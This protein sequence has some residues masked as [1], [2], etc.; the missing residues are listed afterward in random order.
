MTRDVFLKEIEDNSI[1]TVR[2][3]PGCPHFDVVQNQDDPDRYYF[4]EVYVD[5]GAYATHTRMPHLASWR[6][7]AA[8]CLAERKP[9]NCTMIFSRE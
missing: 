8:E 3:E 4:Y 7:A 1:A 2:D 5:E 6:Q 9:I